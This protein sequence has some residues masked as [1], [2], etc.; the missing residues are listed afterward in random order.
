MIAD[1][2][3]K[4]SIGDIV[5]IHAVR[6]LAASQAFAMVAF[7]A[8]WVLLAL[9]TWGHASGPD[10]AVGDMTRALVRAYA[11]LGGVD[12]SGRGDERSLM[13]VWAKLGLVIYAIEALW[14]GVFGQRKPLALWRIASTS[15]LVAQ[16]GYIG[17][18]V[19][20]GDLREAT[21]M[22]IVFPVLAGLSTA[23]AAAAHRL[24]THV[25][26][27]IRKRQVAGGAGKPVT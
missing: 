9:A 1:L 20:T 8:G 18:L 22:L 2:P 25:E 12:E 21:L 10:T 13:A 16:L 4:R 23:W 5:A 3:T 15:W 26:N 11:W 17:A 6:Y 24:A 7:H 14:R 19:P 27:L